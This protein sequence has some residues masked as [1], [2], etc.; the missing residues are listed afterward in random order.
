MSQGPTAM[1]KNTAMRV[2]R[3]AAEGE[4]RYPNLIFVRTILIILLIHGL[5]VIHKLAQN[6]RIA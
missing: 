3:M 5:L 2:L 1:Q 6:D 4:N